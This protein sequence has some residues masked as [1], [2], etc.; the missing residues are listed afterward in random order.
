MITNILMSLNIPTK[1]RLVAQKWGCGS[2]GQRVG[3][4]GDQEKVK[5]TR[6]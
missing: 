6:I 4:R 2:L 5:N 1:Y 3:R